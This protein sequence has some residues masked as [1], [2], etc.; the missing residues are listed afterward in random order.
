VLLLVG[1]EC[2]QPATTK[3]AA[4]MARSAEVGFMV[5]FPRKDGAADGVSSRQRR[6]PF[7]LSNG[8]ATRQF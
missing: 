4:S 1:L 2:P 8:D 3:I 6:A 7:D 5:R